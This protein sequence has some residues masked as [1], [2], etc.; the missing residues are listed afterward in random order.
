MNLKPLLQSLFMILSSL[1]IASLAVY[2]LRE[3]FSREKV[4]ILIPEKGKSSPIAI[5]QKKVV[6]GRNPKCSLQIV[7]PHVST[8]HGKFYYSKGSYRIKD[9]NSKNG[10]FVNDIRINESELESGDKVKFGSK[11]FKVKIL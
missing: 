2:A 7:D 9:L 1:I 3:S 10:T 4:L 11:V 6:V 8:K 5:R